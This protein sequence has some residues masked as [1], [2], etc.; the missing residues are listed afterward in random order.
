M[1]GGRAVP[2]VGVRIHAPAR[3]HLGFLDLGGALGRRFGSLGL[4]L[5]APETCVRIEKAGEDGLAGPDAARAGR[6]RDLVR[7]A[8]AIDLPLAISIEHALPA[9]G[10]LGS[11]TQLALAVAMGVARLAGRPLDVRDAARLLGR[12]RR[13]AIGIGAFETGGVILDGGKPVTPVAEDVGAAPPILARLPVPQ[14]WRILLVFDAAKSGLSGEAE[15]RAMETL[16]PFAETLAAHLCHLVVMQALP[17]LAEG[18]AAGFGSAVGA[19]QR[20]LGDHYAA[21]QGGGR[22]TSADVAH[23]L[24]FLEENGIS[25]VGQTSWGPTGFAIVE[26]AARGEALLQALRTRYADRANLSF[27]CVRGNNRGARIVDLPGQD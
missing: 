12:G 9:H 21:A 18:D 17:A 25:G 20:H 5:D 19:V 15:T 24:G 10:G 1:T 23:A 6:A 26:S 2:G 7:A 16:P 13:S 11:G 4:T 14:A 8:L 3:L 22:H 27:A